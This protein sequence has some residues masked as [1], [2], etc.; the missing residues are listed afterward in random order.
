ME[1]EGLKQI[2]KVFREETREISD[3]VT[4]DLLALEEASPAEAK[5]RIESLFREAHTLKGGAG[6]LGIEDIA[7]L[8]HDIETLLGQCQRGERKFEP[9]Y[10]DAI[11]AAMDEVGRRLD[12]VLA[13]QT[14][15]GEGVR[16][17]QLRLQRAVAGEVD[18]STSV[19]ADVSSA[20]T[21]AAFMRVGV[22]RLEALSISVDE[23]LIARLRTS[24]RA[25]EASR[26]ATDLERLLRGSAA[27]MPIETTA[28]LRR[29]HRETATMARE[30]VLDTYY[31][32]SMS[33]DLRY[34]LR[35]LQVVP[36]SS[37]LDPLR[38]AVRDHARAAGVETALDLVGSEI[39][40]DRRIVEALRAPLLHLLRNAVDHG[41]EKPDE[42]RKVKKPPRA[43]LRIEVTV[44]GSALQLTVTDDGRGI[45]VERIRKK[46]LQLGVLDA[47]RLTKANEET[48]LSLIWAPG[49]STAD[50]VSQTSGRGVG[51]DSV[52]D[53]VT[54]LGGR[55]DVQTRVGH[56]TTFRIHVPLMLT[57]AMGLLVE[58]GGVPYLVPLMEVEG[59]RR[60][61][62][63][64]LRM[65]QGASMM[66]DETRAMPVISLASVLSGAPR[67]L[68]SDE[69]PLVFILGDELGSVALAVDAIL[70]E[71]EMSPR[72]L[73][74]ELESLDHL[75]GAARTGDGKV[76]IVL[77]PG[78]LIRR[79]L[80]L[81][82]EADRSGADMRT[83]LVVED[84][85][86][87]RLLM[88]T[89]LESAGFH[90]LDASDGEE[91]LEVLHGRPVDAIVS[92]V[93]MP[94]LDGFELTRRVRTT[95]GL[96]KLPI[97]LVTSLASEQDRQEGLAVGATTYL[98]KGETPPETIVKVL[99]GFLA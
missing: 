87:S 56:G 13:G 5:K 21:S 10:T 94:R 29:V 57:T 45:D 91:A 18:T 95:M 42:R 31:M 69:Q 7:A 61:E 47:N 52:R 41:I 55:V 66:D 20:S 58:A 97:L 54:K 84:T 99:R 73:P 28:A 70:G 93:R 46:A 12:A 82:R 78:G 43:R 19:G 17:S 40:A 64:S 2:L 90:V 75:A 65:V 36:V 53:D 62:A 51:L 24:Q 72:P 37:V 35:S 67:A 30:L 11:L 68:R 98:V 76:V 63:G 60:V 6:S 59:V 1:L 83:I 15:G 89:V 49:F 33:D 80:D 27:T 34:S 77:H 22:D 79:A 50:Q 71:R 38:R 25:T 9:A 88:R 4:A 96:S 74:P 81:H 3:R 39:T 26:L 16:A 14:E 32:A 23:L 86:T 85:A 44:L 8:A 92:D 48:L